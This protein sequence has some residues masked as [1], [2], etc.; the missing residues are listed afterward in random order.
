MADETRKL[1]VFIS[2]SRDELDFADVVDAALRLGGFG[3]ILDRHGISPGEEWKKRLG[4]LIRD[5]D[6]VVFVTSPLSAESEICA[7]E[8]KEAVRLGKR[9]VPVLP[10]ALGDAKP[11]P[12]LADLDY[13]FCYAEPKRPGSG[14]GPGLV[15][16]AAALNT[17]L[18]WL[19][20]HTRYLQRAMEWDAGGRAA[21]RL[22]SGPDIATAKAWAS[23]RPRNAP[24]PTPLQLDF[25]KASEAEALRQQDAEAQRLREIAE[26]QAERGKALAEQEAAQAREAEAQKREAE[27]AKLVVRRTRLGLAAALGL[28]LL[29]GVFAFFATQ[30][31]NRAQLQETRANEQRDQALLQQSRALAIL[32]QEASKQEANGTSDQ[33]T[34]MLLALEALPEPGFGGQRRLSSEAASALH[35]AW[36]RNRE[37]T[38]AGHREVVVSAS[39]SPD[40]THVVTASGDGTAR[41]WDLRGARPSFVPLEGHQGKVV[42]A[43]FSPDGTH[44]VT[45]SYDHTARVWDLRGARP[46]FVALEGHQSIVNSASF[47]PDGTHVVTASED[48]TARVW[49]LRGARPSFVALEGHQGDVVSASFSPDGTHV[50]T[51]SGDG[52]ARVWDVRGERPSFVA[53]EGHQGDVVSASFSPDGTHVV[54]ASGDETARVWDLRGSRPSFVPLEGHRNAV[55]SASFSPDGTHVVTAS[56]DGTARVWDLRG[57]R[58]SFVALEGHQGSGRLGFVQPGRDACRHG[59]LGRDGAGVGCA[60]RAAELRPPRRA[61]GSGPLRFVQPG[62]DACRHGVR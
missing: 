62:R 22:L 15:S 32:A 42:S 38:L 7:W 1:N 16:L 5:S 28:A 51:A 12:E 58:P 41:V 17:D 11:P 30:E 27:Q 52:T 56:G 21:N 19:R 37:M 45:A 23:R 39:F 50:V 18:D 48:T 13:I 55:A 29:A 20:E 33:P 59:V 9:I 35:Q 53:L 25:I 46:S 61:S 26:A 31:R 2:Y 44:V 24:E 8:V 34:A 57:A 47:S 6:T 40:G 4:A 54:T 60:R 43:S 36:L 49:D 14:F 10:R 3:T